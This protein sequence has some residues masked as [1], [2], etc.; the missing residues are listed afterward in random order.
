[1]LLPSRVFLEI[2]ASRMGVEVGSIVFM[3]YDVQVNKIKYIHTVVH[4]LAYTAA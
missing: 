1:M 2:I 4:R 3:L